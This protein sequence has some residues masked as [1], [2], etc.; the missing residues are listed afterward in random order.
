M[1]VEGATPLVPP[2]REA[3][4]EDVV[5]PVEARP[6][7]PAQDRLD[8]VAV[9]DPD[10]LRGPQMDDAVDDG[11]SLGVPVGVDQGL[12]R[13]VLKPTAPLVP[14][15]FRGSALLEHL[16]AAAVAAVVR[17]RAHERVVDVVG[18]PVTEQCGQIGFGRE[19]D[20]GFAVDDAA[21]LQRH[22]HA[23]VDQAERQRRGRLAA[24]RDESE[25]GRRLRIGEGTDRQRD[26][27][28][29]RGVARLAAAV[30]DVLP[31]VGNPGDV[32]FRFHGT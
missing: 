2:V 32:A 17:P 21:D 31:V 1:L 11:E 14:G 27:V 19:A 20:P 3:D 4:E 23:I 26:V 29:E 10:R 6:H 30:S 5:R 28:A 22:E 9:R 24:G 13:I 18:P 16:E 15:G 25:H 8:P 12:L 7:G